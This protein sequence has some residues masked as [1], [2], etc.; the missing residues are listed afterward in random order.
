MNGGW[1]K[2]HRKIL[3]NNWLSKNRVYSNFEAFMFLLLQANHK[4]AIYPL[5]DGVIEI[6]R[7]QLV[8]SQKKLCK[9]FN[10]SNSKLRNYLKTAKTASMIHTETTSKTTCITIIKYDTY[11]SNQIDN[12]LIVNRKQIENK[13][14]SNTNNNGKNVKNEKN[15]KKNNKN[16]CHLFDQFWSFYPK[17]VNKKRAA[18]L[19]EK[20]KDE[21]KEKCIEGAKAY[22]QHVKMN[23]IYD[24]YTM[25]PSTFINGENWEDFIH[26]SVTQLHPDMYRFDSTGMFVVGFCSKCGSCESYE[27]DSV[28]FD[29]SRCCKEQI[30]PDRLNKA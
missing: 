10:W 13:S 30:L 11:Q 24:Q 1:I 8:T 22:K 2:V 29:D 16:T 23:K 25:H 17:K 12:K 4:D 14:K 19:F 27:K 7:G 15:V 28:I 9:Q 26:G 3:D 6:K 20:L 21:N 18:Q 5:V